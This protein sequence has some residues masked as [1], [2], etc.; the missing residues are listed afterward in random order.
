MN[1][2]GIN[3]G[4]FFKWWAICCVSIKQW[5]EW[6]TILNLNFCHF[7]AIFEGFFQYSVVFCVYCWI[8]S[9][10]VVICL[11]YVFC[12]TCVKICSLVFVHVLV[13]PLLSS[14]PAHIHLFPVSISVVSLYSDLFPTQQSTIVRFTTCQL[15]LSVSTS[16]HLLFWSYFPPRCPFCFEIVNFFF[17]IFK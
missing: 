8:Y 1:H 4:S 10:L 16:F 15:L 12:N 2:S 9:F 6:E 5:T 17:E 11:F 13:S 14:C 3:K 7:V